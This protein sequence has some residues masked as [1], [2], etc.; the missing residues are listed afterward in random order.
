M[1]NVTEAGR[2]FSALLQTHNQFP[3]RNFESWWGQSIFSSDFYCL[4]LSLKPVSVNSTSN[5]A[6]SITN[7]NIAFSDE[8]LIGET[9]VRKK[10]FFTR[11]IFV[12]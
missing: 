6:M 11:Y 10:C 5:I 1:K 8:P 3:I 7:S 12:V 4:C 9:V 2:D